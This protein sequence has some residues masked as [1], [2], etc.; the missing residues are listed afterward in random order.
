[1]SPIENSSQN[2]RTAM[3]SESRFNFS[4]HADLP[5][6]TQCCRDVNIYLTPYDVLRMRRALRMGSREFLEKHTLIFP[7][8]NTH[9][10]VVL[11]AMDDATLSCKMVM[12][13]GCQVYQDRPWACRM[14][15]LD[16][17]GHS[18]E[19]CMFVNKSRCFGLGEPQSSTVQKWLE[20]QGVEPYLEMERAFHAVM[21]ERF[22]PGQRMDPGL[23]KFLFLAY[24]L[25]QF[26]TLLD[27]KDFRDICQI[28]NEMLH[29]VKDDD[30]ELL[31]L[32]FR[33]IRNQLEELL[34][35][36]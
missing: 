14:Y 3:T 17:A 18:D 33:Y 15:P 29:R 19:Y 4:C 32:A 27:D 22:Q 12:D 23:G 8:K 26:A 9:I 20:N 24:D 25:D 30:E 5:C 34:S 6:F 1:M 2:D 13:A 11:L 7:D 21:P 10:P 35:D 36:V 28:D 16:L 31:Q